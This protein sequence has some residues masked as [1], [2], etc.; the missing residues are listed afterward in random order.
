MGGFDGFDGGGS[1]VLPVGGLL[2]AVFRSVGGFDG[3]GTVL[4]PDGGLLEVLVCGAA[5]FSDN[6]N[7]A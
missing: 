3:G 4:F 2:T 7:K 1:V 5:S 6:P